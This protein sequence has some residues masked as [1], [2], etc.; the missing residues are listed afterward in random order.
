MFSVDDAFE[1]IPPRRRRGLIGVAL[2]LVVALVLAATT[3]YGRAPL[4]STAAGIGPGGPPTAGSIAARAGDV[5]A[6]IWG[7]D[8]SDWDP[9]L[10][11]TYES[12]TT[13]AQ[14][15]ESLTAIDAAGVVQPALA[16]SWSVEDGERRVVF[17]LRSGIVFSDGTPITAQNVVASWLRLLDPARHSPLVS[18][19]SDVIGAN[20]RW[21]GTG[22][23]DA[24]GITADGERV[25]VT[26]RRP[27]PYFPSAASSPSLA[28]LPVP[29]ASFQGPLLPAGIVVSG[30]YI[31]VEQGT[32]AI[33]LEAN[34]HYWAGPPPLKV[35]EIIT[36]L[37]DLSVVEAFDQGLID[38]SALDAFDA[39]WVRYDAVLGGQLQSRFEL[40]VD[41]Y[42]FDTTRPPFDDARVRRAFAE[43]VDWHRMV[44]LTTPDVVPATSLMPPGVPG[45]S[46]TD[47]TP[48]HDPAA[49]RALLAAA[50]YPGGVGF[51]DIAL[52]T[53]G[54]LW[55]EPI[56]A[57]LQRELGITVRQES[58]ISSQ[59]FARLAGPERPAFWALTWVADY[60]APQDFLGLLLETGSRSNVGRWSDPAYD[61][62]LAAA[63][64][65]SDIAAQTAGYD[66]AQAI[67]QTEVP[68]IPVAY[69]YDRWA[70]A[71]TGLVGTGT[72]GMGILRFAGLAWVGR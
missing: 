50:G 11:D 36:D 51:P 38:Y 14:V 58:M 55:D 42:G 66:A 13:I 52:L 7:Y 18:L 23:V 35:L 15:Y 5:E 31:P 10:Q 41:Y 24:V 8:P 72:S 34:P 19:L 64:A 53:Q 54:Y 70:L 49:A 25:I 27:A 69:T 47:F 48:S 3:W 9:A 29:G 1:P 17:T 33:R 45:R 32:T 4:H 6:R 20:E 57:D 39:G 65:T 44:Q 43:A 30:A 22:S 16:Q 62:A 46:A 60:P 56:A 28:V 67:L 71:R 37:G 26:F 2:L 59:Y 61:A 63:A 40:S 12:A 21:A 68:V